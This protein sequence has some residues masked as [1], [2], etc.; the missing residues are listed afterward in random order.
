MSRPAP[1][2]RI[3][4][5]PSW[6]ARRAE[7]SAKPATH[8][9]E[10]TQGP[11]LGLLLG[12]RD[13]VVGVLPEDGERER[14][15]EGDPA[16]ENLMGRAMPRRAEGGSARLSVLHKVKGKRRMLACRADKLDDEKPFTYRPATQ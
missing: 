6:T 7:S 16:L 11:P 15:G 5:T 2:T 14:I 13:C 10:E 12:E 8:R 1:S 3:C 9:D 4:R